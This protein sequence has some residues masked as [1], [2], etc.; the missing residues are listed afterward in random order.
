MT[1]GM[2]VV[3]ALAAIAAGVPASRFR[4][5]SRRAN[6]RPSS[7]KLSLRPSAERYSKAQ[8]SAIDIAVRAQ[9]LLEH[10]KLAIELLARR[11]QHP[12]TVAPGL[13]PRAATGSAAV[14]ASPAMN[15]RRFIKFRYVR[16]CRAEHLRHLAGTARAGGSSRAAFSSVL[17]T[18]MKRRNS[19][20]GSPPRQRCRGGRRARPGRYRIGVWTRA[21]ELNANSGA[22]QAL[23][24]YGYGHGQN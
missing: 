7:G 9:S 13:R 14:A 4:S 3:A 18:L 10:L 21:R 11:V 16:R 6:W 12:D 15:S 24:A 17:R 19:S 23:R 8:V 5:T 22:P 20:R 1:T 2:V